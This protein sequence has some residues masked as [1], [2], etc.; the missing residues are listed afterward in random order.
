MDRAH[1]KGPSKSMGSGQRSLIEYAKDTLAGYRV[2]VTEA[3]GP[4]TEDRVDY[5]SQIKMNKDFSSESFVSNLMEL[6]HGYIAVLEE[7]L[8]RSQFFYLS[9]QLSLDYHPNFTQENLPTSSVG[10]THDM[11][12]TCFGFQETQMYVPLILGNLDL[13]QYCRIRRRQVCGYFNR[14]TRSHVELKHGSF[15]QESTPIP[16]RHC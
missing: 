3:G 10:G 8:L 2:L 15:T 7:N 13:L 11:R 16:Q 6:R 1:S 12:L 5:S 4:E 14:T 9:G